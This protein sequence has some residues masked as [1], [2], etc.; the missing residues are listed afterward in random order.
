MQKKTINTKFF[1]NTLVNNNLINKYY[2]NKL[3]RNKKINVNHT[4]LNNNYK[5]YLKKNIYIKKS[6]FIKKFSFKLIKKTK[7]V[8]Y[9]LNLPNLYNVNILSDK[10]QIAN[11]KYY[12]SKNN[13][14]FNKL[15]F[16]KKKQLRKYSFF[17][18]QFKRK[19]YIL[20][21]SSYNTNKYNQI[22]IIIYKLL[23]FLL[24]LKNKNIN[25]AK[26]FVKKFYFKPKKQKK[27][28][29]FLYKKSHKN[30]HRNTDISFMKFYKSIFFYLIKKIYIIT[31]KNINRKQVLSFI[32]YLFKFSNFDYYTKNKKLI[33]KNK[34]FL[35][36][37]KTK[38][39]KRRIGNNFFYKK[40]LYLERLQD[41]YYSSL[42][43]FKYSKKKK[44]KKIIK[45][46]YIYKKKNKKTN[47]YYILK[48]KKSYLT[49]L[50][51]YKLFKKK[52]L[53]LKFNFKNLIN[54][55]NNTDSYSINKLNYNNKIV[56]FVFLNKKLLILN[57]IL[58]NLNKYKTFNSK[59]IY[60]YIK[61]FFINY[62][63]IKYSLFKKKRID[64]KKINFFY[65]NIYLNTLLDQYYKNIIHFNK[66]ILLNTNLFN[67]KLNESLSKKANKKDKIS[68]IIYTYLNLI[69]YFKDKFYLNDEIT[70]N[71]ITIKKK[72]KNRYI[73]KK[74]Q[75]FKKKKINFKKNTY[76]CTY[77]KLK[78]YLY[79]NNDNI[80][81]KYKYQVKSNLN[82]NSNYL[83]ELYYINKLN[84]IYKPLHV[85]YNITTKNTRYLILNNRFKILKSNSLGLLKIS[86]KDMRQKK[87]KLK[88]AE[89]FLKHFKFITKKNK[90]TFNEIHFHLI[91]HKYFTYLIFKLFRKYIRKKIKKI[92]K[93]KKKYFIRTFINMISFIRFKKIKYKKNFKKNIK[94]YNNK[95]FLNNLIIKKYNKFV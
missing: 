73:K 14:R 25:Q 61:H 37:K 49:N 72:I 75:F 20:L 46:N 50:N 21:N 30:N 4:F 80:K 81:I 26:L 76:L 78:K 79:L 57:F 71:I 54:K 92:E 91:R 5:T 12:N 67:K 59:I 47:L 27:T 42:T 84:N 48:N 10:N 16:S 34:L 88:L 3:F 39:I 77:L 68:N 45:V 7:N 36:L 18:N 63:K 85:Y 22:K 33:T 35:N 90:N 24:Y 82:Y 70:K 43:K 40:K 17:F 15:L 89:Y 56:N 74:S 31:S 53:N 23:N 86:R 28:N 60:K 6:D 8:N 62:K 65:Y 13:I 55:I 29:D 19:L 52:K 38:K 1:N 9:F 95:F 94:I 66:N 51:I 41:G 11:K 93:K 69:D 87:S 44:I 83:H 32:F 64:K 58:K 2:L